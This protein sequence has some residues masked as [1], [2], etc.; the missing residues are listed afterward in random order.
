MPYIEQE[1]AKLS[2][3]SVLPYLT[4]HMGMDIEVLTGVPIIYNNRRNLH[5]YRVLHGTTN[6]VMYLHSSPATLL[7]AEI[8]SNILWRLDYILIQA[9]TVDGLFKEMSNFFSFPKTYNFKL[10]PGKCTLFPPQ[11]VGAGE[12]YQLMGFRLTLFVFGIYVT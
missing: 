11:Y 10:H 4:Y 8:R 5:S 1:L 9:A 7:P 12:S 6:A 2:T 3:P